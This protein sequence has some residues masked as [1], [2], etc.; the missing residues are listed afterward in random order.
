MNKHLILNALSFITIV[1]LIYSAEV[2]DIASEIIF[3]VLTILFRLDIVES[4][5]NKIA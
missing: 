5:V 4:K 2:G 1:L 3:A